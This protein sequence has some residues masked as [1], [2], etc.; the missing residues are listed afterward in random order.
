M[1]RADDGYKTVRL[2]SE[3]VEKVQKAQVFFTADGGRSPTLSRLVELALDALITLR[4]SAVP[5]LATGLSDKRLEINA[6]KAALLDEL[7]D[8]EIDRRA[9]ASTDAM[10]HWPDKY[11]AA[12]EKKRSLEHKAVALRRQEHRDA[13]TTPV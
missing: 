1:P 12:L 2:R 11:R 3:T 5:A 7:L 4:A 10:R 9:L 8:A 13:G 6:R